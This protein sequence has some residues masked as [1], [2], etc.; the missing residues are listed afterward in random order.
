MDELFICIKRGE[1]TYKV[2]S[3]VDF[4]VTVIVSL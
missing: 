2:G 3:F 4:V 1:E